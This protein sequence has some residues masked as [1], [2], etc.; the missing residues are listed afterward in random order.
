MMFAAISAVDELGKQRVRIMKRLCED[1]EALKSEG[2]SREARRVLKDDLKD[3]QRLLKRF[4]EDALGVRR[5]V[6]VWGERKDGM[7]GEGRAAV[8]VMVKGDEE[9]LRGE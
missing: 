7:N 8:S 1:L 9:L 2:M 6:G 3:V 5:L 4:G